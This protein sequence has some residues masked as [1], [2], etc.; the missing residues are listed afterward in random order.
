MRL[1]IAAGIAQNP[2]LHA[3]EGSHE[4]GI[5]GPCEGASVRD[6]FFLWQQRER[7]RRRECGQATQSIFASAHLVEPH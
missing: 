2:S 6:P 1:S 3:N 5:E 4:F 7:V